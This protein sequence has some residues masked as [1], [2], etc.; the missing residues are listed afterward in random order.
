MP[1]KLGIVPQ[2]PPRQV[3]END[4]ASLLPSATS[5]AS[6]SVPAADPPEEGRLVRVGNMLQIVPETYEYY[7]YDTKLRSMKNFQHAYSSATK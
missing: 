6:Q 1:T 2:Y 5:A 7:L 3:D 4:T